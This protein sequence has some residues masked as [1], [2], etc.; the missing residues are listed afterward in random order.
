MENRAA[1]GGAE[2]HVQRG[3]PAIRCADGAA[4]ELDRDREA[5]CG[6][7]TGDALEA[8]VETAAAE[9]Q[10]SRRSGII[11]AGIAAK[12]D[13]VSGH[14]AAGLAHAGE[15]GGV[16][17]P[18]FEK[19]N[20]VGRAASSDGERPTLYIERTVRFGRVG[21]ADFTRC[22]GGGA[23]VH[24]GP[25]FHGHRGGVGD[26]GPVSDAEVGVV[27][28]GRRGVAVHG[29]GAA[30]KGEIHVAVVARNVVS[31][32]I[33]R[34]D[35][36][37]AAGL[38]KC[39]DGHAAD[40]GGVSPRGHVDGATGTNE[41]VLG[42]TRAAT[43][44]QNSTRVHGDAGGR[45]I[46]VGDGGIDGGGLADGHGDGSVKC[47]IHQRQRGAG[48]G[49]AAVGESDPTT[50]LNGPREGHRIRTVRARAEGGGV[51]AGIVPLG[52]QVACLI[53][54]VPGTIRPSTPAVLGTGD[55]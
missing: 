37:G 2:L 21:E 8:D 3:R 38:V 32:V 44:I 19:V 9:L 24:R 10:G 42:I 29:Q 33:S 48:E 14:G 31:I 28:G 13:A 25:A 43:E 5:S 45:I 4:L 54:P 15:V 46:S 53:Q 12:L 35:V 23:D 39:G 36:E 51:Q 41:V 7:A 17:R 6:D 11:S 16:D 40:V 27:D 52:V 26:G 20:L 22:A 47:S 34:R 18:S 55:A 1:G 50:G 30:G 49:V